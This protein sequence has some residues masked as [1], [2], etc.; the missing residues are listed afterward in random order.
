MWIR[1]TNPCKL[2]WRLT[3]DQIAPLT[4][5][6]K[7]LLKYPNLREEKVRLAIHQELIRY[8][9]TILK[10]QRLAIKEG[11][12]SKWLSLETI[13]EVASSQEDEIS[14]DERDMSKEEE[15]ATIEGILDVD[16]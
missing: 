3:N 4:E 13:L 9:Q 2:H 6:P 11:P 16:E 1:F 8:T 10:G 12:M 14:L 15:N 7:K 5:I